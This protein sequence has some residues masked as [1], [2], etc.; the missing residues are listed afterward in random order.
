[1]R[2]NVSGAVPLLITVT[3]LAVLMVSATNGWRPRWK[4]TPIV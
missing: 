4:F 1:V 2:Q 3:M